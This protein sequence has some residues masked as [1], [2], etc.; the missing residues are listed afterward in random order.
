MRF[1]PAL[2]L[3]ALVLCS[4]A[5]A[6]CRNGLFGR[7]RCY[8]CQPVPCQPV[9]QGQTVVQSQPVICCPQ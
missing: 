3:L 4:L 6:G 8:Y 9:V 1:R 7:N 2:A 5:L